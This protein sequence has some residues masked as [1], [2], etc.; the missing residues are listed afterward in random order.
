MRVTVTVNDA[1]HHLDVEPGRTLADV[2]AV[3]CGFVE[4]HAACPDG[5]CGTCTVVI[6]GDAIRSCLML[7]AQAADAQVRVGPSDSDIH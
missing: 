2:L 6:D 3:E 7:A 4:V 1:C 5:T